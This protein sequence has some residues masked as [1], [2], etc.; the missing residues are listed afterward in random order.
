LAWSSF[1]PLS[2]SEIGI[3]TPGDGILDFN[4]IAFSNY[5]EPGTEYQSPITHYQLPN[6]MAH[7]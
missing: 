7:W 4:L 5:P 6:L 3:R 1:G 2:V